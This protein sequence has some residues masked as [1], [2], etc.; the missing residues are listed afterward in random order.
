MIEFERFLA[1]VVDGVERGALT[2]HEAAHYLGEHIARRLYCS[3]ATLWTLSGPPGLRVMARVGGFD[4]PGNR[5]LIEPLQAIEAGASAWYDALAGQRVFMSTDTRHDPRL[6]RMHA[7]LALPRRVRSLLQVAIGT[8][9]GLC[10]FVSCTQYDTAR[11][12]T[13]RE[14]AQLQRMAAALSLRRPRADAAGVAAP[15]PRVST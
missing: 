6:P 4:A 15:V 2:Q 14:V 1:R 11:A 9:A 13:P 10:G 8:N 3:S 7:A 5:P 12:W